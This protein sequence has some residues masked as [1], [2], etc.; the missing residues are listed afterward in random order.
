MQEEIRRKGVELMILE[1]VSSC[2]YAF[3]THL[4]DERPFQLALEFE[5]EVDRPACP[6]T[7]VI[8]PLTSRSGKG[9]FSLGRDAK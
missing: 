5:Y 7:A 1:R 2:V 3:S 4:G 6:M 9:K 8:F